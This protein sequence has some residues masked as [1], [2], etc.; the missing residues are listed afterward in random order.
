[1]DGS[2]VV[3]VCSHYHNVGQ[4]AVDTQGLRGRIDWC[5]HGL[6]DLRLGI[7]E[8]QDVE[9][10]IIANAIL[11]PLPL[12][13]VHG[14]PSWFE[15]GRSDW[16]VIADAEESLAD[17]GDPTLPGKQSTCS[18]VKVATL[19]AQLSRVMVVFLLLEHGVDVYLLIVPNI[20]ELEDWGMQPV[21][22]I[23]IHPT[24]FC[25]CYGEVTEL[26]VAEVLSA[27]KIYVRKLQT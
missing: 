14:A 7:I 9:G 6:T 11:I 23:A 18:V 17:H 16:N 8:D 3:A 27:C 15:F 21:G 25:V 1:M 22:G 24:S 10:E 5:F 20:G 2:G 19:V 4:N 12:D 26:G 13:N